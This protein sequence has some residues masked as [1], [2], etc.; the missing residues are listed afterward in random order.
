MGDQRSESQKV[1]KGKIDPK[2]EAKGKKGK[3][4]DYTI[5]KA[6]E[7]MKL[8]PWRALQVIKD[9]RLLVSVF[10]RVISK[11]HSLDDTALELSK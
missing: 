10:S 2:V 7:D 5:E 6:A 4:A 11:E 1:K 8:T 3:K 9:E